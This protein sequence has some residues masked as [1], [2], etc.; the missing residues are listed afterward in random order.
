MVERRHLSPEARLPAFSIMIPRKK[1]LER[2]TQPGLDI[3][4]VNLSKD[5][6][7][8]YYCTT[9][10][11]APMP[12]YFG[13]TT[14]CRMQ[15]STR[16]EETIVP[17]PQ[18]FHPAELRPGGKLSFCWSPPTVTWVSNTDPD[19]YRVS[20]ETLEVT[21]YASCG[22]ANTLPPWAATCATAAAASLKMQGDTLYFVST[23]FDS[24]GLYQLSKGGITLPGGPARLHRAAATC[25]GGFRSDGLPVGYASP[26]ALRSFRQKAQPVQRRGP[27]R[28]LRRPAPD[29]VELHFCTVR[30]STALCSSPSTLYPARNVPRFWMFTAAPKTVY[31][32]VFYHE[33]QH[34]AGKGYFV[35]L[36]NPTGS[37]G[38]GEFMDIREQ[39]YG[40]VDF[41]DIMAFCDAALARLPGNGRGQLLRNRRL[42][43]RLHDQL[44]H[45]PYGPVPGLRQP[46]LHFQL[47]FLLRRFRHWRGLY[48]KIS[49]PPRYAPI[50]RRSGGHSPLKY[51]DQVKTPTLFIH[52][53]EG[54][55][56]PIDPGYQMYTALVAHGVETKMV[57]FK[58]EN[59]ELSRSGKPRHR[60]RRLKE[61]TEWFDVHQKKQEG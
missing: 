25:G 44:D 54:T 30:K 33:M 39:K 48:A 34:W 38:R 37:D 2:L 52:S 49:A 17:G 22:P 23:R 19:F 35:N 16:K 8:V 24:A 36:C 31:G 21:P 13:G 28:P 3:G 45:R 57:C 47:D 50:R 5:Q 32:P 1:R 12:D 61:I 10:I 58:G 41:E 42:L 55:R 9:D 20:Y 40:T 43:R 53:F 15:L 4:E 46:A 14:L 18:G 7:Y 11:T 26:G 29:T 51:A 59:H 56:C 60:I 6:D 27:A